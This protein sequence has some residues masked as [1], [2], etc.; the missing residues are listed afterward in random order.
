VT[1]TALEIAD[2]HLLAGDRDSA[3]QV[4]ND[5]L[6]QHPTD[7]DARRR[8]IRIELGLPDGTS[9]ALDDLNAI[10]APNAQDY[11]SRAILLIGQGDLVRG[12]AT[13]EQ[14]W[15]LEPRRYAEMY[16]F[17]LK[18]AGMTDRALEVLET[19]P[20]SWRWLSWRGEVHWGRGEHQ[21]AVN[22]FSEAITLLDAQIVK[23][24]EKRLLLSMKPNLLI[25]RAL[26]YRALNDL[27]AAEQD[28]REAE[29]LVPTDK[30]L[31]F[32]R[33]LILLMQG[34][35]AG[36]ISLCREG[37]AR[38]SDDMRAA[39]RAE[40]EADPRFQPLLAA[41]IEIPPPTSQ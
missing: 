24:K 31:L 26:A 3:L 33:G 34:D 36:A 7:D 12:A 5:Y 27:S 20:K 6:A 4:L 15:K 39:M 22:A 10:T 9:A 1:Y 28:Y 25:R 13:Y 30:T 29:L 35:T 19:L 40:L 32:N 16:V 21:S 11:A 18:E 2:A 41:L 17:A 37:W 14:A 23:V 8:R 38:A